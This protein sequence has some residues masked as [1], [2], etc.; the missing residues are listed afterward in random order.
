MVQHLRNIAFFSVHVFLGYEFLDV[1]NGDRGIHITARAG[2][3]TWLVA[4]T[5]ANSRERIIVL[6]KLQSLSVTALGGQFD[7]ALDR[8]MCR[9]RRLARCSPALHHIAAVCAVVVIVG[10]PIPWNGHVRI[11][12]IRYCGIER[13]ILLSESDRVCLAVFDAHAAGNAFVLVDPSGKVRADRVLGS[14]ELGYAQSVTRAPAAVAYGSRILEA[15]SLVDLVHQSVIL[16]SLKDLIGFLFGDE[17]MGSD[18]REVHG[19]VVEIHAHVIFKVPAALAHKAAGT[20][21]GTGSDRDGKSIFN[22]R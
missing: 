9:A 17:A 1:V 8:D 11:I 4:D 3:F 14:E 5:P 22:E 16:R 12:W 10:F 15:R 18:F 2:S 19:I 6:Y 21:A 20:A 13:R 7:I